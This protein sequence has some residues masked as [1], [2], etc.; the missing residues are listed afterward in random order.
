MDFR[1]RLEG[2]FHLAAQGF[3]KR[4]QPLLDQGDE[5]G[6]DLLRP[7]PVA[8]EDVGRHVDVDPILAEAGI[9]DELGFEG[10]EDVELEVGIARG[11]PS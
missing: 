10:N 7:A 11:R 8:E 6:F 2:I 9:L 3:E 4:S 1:Q 5:L